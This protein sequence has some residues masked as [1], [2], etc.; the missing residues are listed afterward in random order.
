MTPLHL[1]RFEAYLTGHGL[2]RTKPRRL[3]Y[4]A[5]ATGGPQTPSQLSVA[6]DGRVDRATVYRTVEFFLANG[7]AIRTGHHAIELGEAFRPHHH[8]LECTVCGRS[9]SIDDSE[10]EATLTAVATRHGYRLD[11]HQVELTGVCANCQATIK[12]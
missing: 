11:G 12:G 2:S 1:D 9:E 4:Q 10:L 3:L 5:L 8:H 6:L 7:M